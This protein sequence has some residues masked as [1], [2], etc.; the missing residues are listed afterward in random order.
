MIG[1]NFIIQKSFQ[2]IS[3]FHFRFIFIQIRWRRKWRW[4][5]VSQNGYCLEWLIHFSRAFHVSRRIQINSIHFHNVTWNGWEWFQHKMNG[6]FHVP[7]TTNPINIWN[8]SILKIWT[9]SFHSADSECV[10]LSW[11]SNY[12]ILPPSR[13]SQHEMNE[14]YQSG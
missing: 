10:L 7:C 4:R 9:T 6:I 2:Q 14:L 5:W 3:T 13:C 8:L 1:M 12:F 11:Y